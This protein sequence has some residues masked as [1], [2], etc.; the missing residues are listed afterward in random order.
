MP[1]TL[2]SR[3]KLVKAALIDAEDITVNI[4]PSFDIIDVEAGLPKVAGGSGLPGTPYD[5]QIR[6][7]RNDGFVKVWDA[8]N[9]V[10]QKLLPGPGSTILGGGS[11][12]SSWENF[13]STLTNVTLGTG[14]VQYGNAIRLPGNM[15]FVKMGFVLGTG[16]L[17]SS[18]LIMSLPTQYPIDNSV[19]SVGQY[20]VQDVLGYATAMSSAGGAGRLPLGALLNAVGPPGNVS[21]QMTTNAGGPG[22]VSSPTPFTWAAGSQL[23]VNL[24]YRTLA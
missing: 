6:W 15:I 18:T 3:L 24:L 10:W 11:G 23:D 21:F 5:G 8:A 17:L 4:N 1:A 9:A 14:G 2:T 12:I 7:D 16:G 20:K 22:N 19:G 13:T